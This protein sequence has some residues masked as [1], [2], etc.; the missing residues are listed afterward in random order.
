MQLTFQNVDC[1]FKFDSKEQND[2][3]DGRRIDE[4]LQLAGLTAF[5]GFDEKSTERVDELRQ[6]S[7]QAEGT[8]PESICR[9]TLLPVI[10]DVSLEIAN[11]KVSS[12]YYCQ[13]LF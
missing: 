1:N 4:H 11:Y 9:L 3:F 7:F 5:G 13:C 8:S 10:K 12:T 6:D 2:C